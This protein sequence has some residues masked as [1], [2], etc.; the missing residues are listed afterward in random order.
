MALTMITLT[1]TILDPLTLDPAVGTVTITS[2][3]ELSDPDTPASYPP[4]N[5]TITLDAGGS[6]S[7]ALP[8]TNCTDVSP[9]GWGYTLLIQ[10]DILCDTRLIE[11][12]CETVGAEVDMSALPNMTSS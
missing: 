5:T 9:A 2:P 12:D 3:W 10:T 4:V 1:G 8:A 11:L 7:I 6:F